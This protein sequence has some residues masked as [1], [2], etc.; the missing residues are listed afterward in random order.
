MLTPVPCPIAPPPFDPQHHAR[1]AVSSPQPKPSPSQAAAHEATGAAGTQAPA[2]SHAPSAA[3]VIVQAV[4]SGLLVAEQEPAEQVPTYVHSAAGQVTPVQGSPAQHVAHEAAAQPS[5]H[6]TRQA[7]LPQQSSG[8]GDA[9][10]GGARE[11]EAPSA[12][13]V[14]RARNAPGRSIVPTPRR[15]LRCVSPRHRRMCARA[16]IEEGAANYRLCAAGARAFAPPKR[17]G[18]GVRY[19]VRWHLMITWTQQALKT[20]KTKP[21]LSHITAQA[22]Q[23]ASPN[24]SR[25][26]RQRV[27]A[28]TARSAWSPAH[29]PPPPPTSP[30]ARLFRFL[31]LGFRVLGF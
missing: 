9:R 19:E 16:S 7:L 18:D 14:R 13:S 8:T 17:G 4:P 31:G 21:S 27:A 10:A 12:S 3:V 6:S 29:A 2:A 22:R 26:A 23:K 30:H 24:W 25:I 1:L 11:I 28:I 20:L 15:Y 5:V